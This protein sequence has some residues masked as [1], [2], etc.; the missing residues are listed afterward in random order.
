MRRFRRANGVAS[1]K[2]IRR[3]VKIHKR[4]TKLRK[5]LGATP[6]TSETLRGRNAT[7]AR[8]LATANSRIVQLEQ[9]LEAAETRAADAETMAGIY[10]GEVNSLQEAA[11]EL[12]EAD[13]GTRPNPQDDSD[14]TS[15]S[16]DTAEL[17]RELEEEE[18]SGPD[19]IG[20]PD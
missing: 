13:E 18:F 15:S 14:W 4:I 20:F 2:M 11:G 9:E 17:E 12:D 8:E 10:Q 5:E 6:A 3:R 16:G 1:Q 19:F 7:L